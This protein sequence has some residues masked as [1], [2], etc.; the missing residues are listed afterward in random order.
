[1]AAVFSRKTGSPEAMCNES[2][3]KHCHMNELKWIISMKAKQIERLVP[4][5]LFWS[6]KEQSQYCPEIAC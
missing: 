2:N 3:R 6:I 1:M 5:I 4:L